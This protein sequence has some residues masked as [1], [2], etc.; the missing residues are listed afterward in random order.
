MS[1]TANE[2]QPGPHWVR[3]QPDAEWFYLDVQKPDALL[4][5]LKWAE[6]EPIRRPDDP[7]ESLPAGL[8]SQLYNRNRR[9]E[10]A[11]AAAVEDI[12][13]LVLLMPAGKVLMAVEYDKISIRMWAGDDK[14]KRQASEEAK[15]LLP[16]WKVQCHPESE[17]GFISLNQRIQ[18]EDIDVTIYNLIH[19][20]TAIQQDDA[21]HGKPETPVNRD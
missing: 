17:Y 19:E 8:P 2:V 18:G 4:Y 11:L 16:G 14:T 15:A 21:E 10:M 12:D 3:V 6:F 9:A 20:E 1:L 5:G 7:A 13:K